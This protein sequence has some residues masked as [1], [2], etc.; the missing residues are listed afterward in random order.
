MYNEENINDYFDINI[1]NS[2]IGYL[3]SKYVMDMQIKLF[4]KYYQTNIICLIL[5]NI[6]GSDDHFCK[7]GR[8]IPSLIYKFK[9]A[10]EDNSD[11]FIASNENNIVNLIYIK[12]LINIIENCIYNDTINGKIIIYN[13]NNNINL[14]YLTDIMKSIFNFNNKIIFNENVPTL[15]NTIPN[16]DKFNILF[17]DFKFS[18]LNS[19]LRETIE[20]YINN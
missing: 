15:N 18:D 3:S 17:P 11:I 14:K 20:F 13:K 2:N 1:N 19:S 12:D 4:E 16:I 10:Q 5:P 8:I 7:N 6:F 9:M